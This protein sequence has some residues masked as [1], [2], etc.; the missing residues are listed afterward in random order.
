MRE[1]QPMAN[2]TKKMIVFTSEPESGSCQCCPKG[3]RYAIPGYWLVEAEA[4]HM[5]R[6]L[7]GP[8]DSR[9]EARAARKARA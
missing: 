4:P 7:A 6:I 3:T 1:K 2:R 5:A 9:R 8:F